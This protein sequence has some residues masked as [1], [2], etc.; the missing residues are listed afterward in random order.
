MADHRIRLT[1]RDLVLA[2]SAANAMAWAVF[3]MDPD[4]SQEYWL[5]GE[6]LQYFKAGGMP[7][8]ARDA[9]K[10]ALIKDAGK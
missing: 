3:P 8:V 7:L 2:R 9:R 1:D 10:K 5:L 4:L 6:R